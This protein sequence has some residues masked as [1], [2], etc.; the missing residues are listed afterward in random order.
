VTTFWQWPL[1]FVDKIYTSLKDWYDVPVILPNIGRSDHRAVV[2]TPKQ[3]PTDRG[4]DVTV[5]VRSQDANG[6][7][8]LSQAIAE[9]D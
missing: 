4:E 6:R 2:M 8:L 5:V 9:T 1:P 7:A 3:R